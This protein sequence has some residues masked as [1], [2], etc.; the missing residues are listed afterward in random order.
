MNEKTTKVVVFLSGK[1]GS[2]KT[3]VAIAFA[4]LLSDIGKKV[5]LIDF[6]LS[7]NGA[8]YFFKTYFKRSQRG[9]W[10]SLSEAYSK[11]TSEQS[12][13]PNSIQVAEGFKFVPSRVSL[14]EKGPSYDAVPYEKDFLKLHI[15]TPIIATATSDGSDFILIDCQAGFA[16]TSAAA[17]EL[18]DQ[19]I[20]VTEADSISSDAADNLLIQMGASLPRERRYLVNKIDVRD[21]ETYRQMRNVFQTLNRLPPL[22]F[23]FGVRNAFGSRQIPVDVEKPNALLFALFETVKAAFPEIHKEIEAFKEQRVDALFDKYDAELNSLLEAKRD[24]EINLNE[25]RAAEY[26]YRRWLANI[27]SWGGLGIGL[28]TSLLAFSGIGIWT[29]ENLKKY[30]LP[31]ITGLG[32]ITAVLIVFVYRRRIEV[33]WRSEHEGGNL[34]KKLAALQVDVDRYK[35]LLLVQSRDYLID[36]EIATRNPANRPRET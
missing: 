36:S 26:N 5:V 2:G 33:R 15:L 12:S 25:V 1:G 11:K 16:V 4:K 8:S 24:L 31:F 14:G 30:I 6:D 32:G 34:E 27:L 19:A 23:D 17:S 35:S 22:P 9:V 28:S 3:T 10:E 7:T 21:A 20:I 18:G 29:D 13:L